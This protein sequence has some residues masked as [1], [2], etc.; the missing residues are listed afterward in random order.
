VSD[1]TFGGVAVSLAHGRE[2]A[3]DAGRRPSPVP[4]TAMRTRMFR[5]TGT[6]L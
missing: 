6:R 1:V 4:R 3:C 5:R 2:D